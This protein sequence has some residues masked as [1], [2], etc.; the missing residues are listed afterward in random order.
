MAQ[1]A[2]MIPTL[3]MFGSTVTKKPAY[4]D[5][6]YGI[7]RRFR[8]SG[9]NLLFGTDVGYMPDYSTQDE[10]D[11]LANCGLNYSDI[12][13]MLTVGPAER[14]GKAT[15]KGSLDPGKLA[16]FVVLGSDPASNV[17]AFADVRVT[18]R[19]GTIL[20]QAGK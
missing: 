18:I 4:L 19:G 10:F 14:M 8:A 12:L 2:S 11:A 15:Q 9:G 7:V 6:I 17:K 16:D 20:W 1:K 3:K 5:P 13:R